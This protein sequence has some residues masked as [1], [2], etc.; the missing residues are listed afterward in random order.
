ML[1]GIVYGEPNRLFNSLSYSIP[2]VQVLA[3]PKDPQTILKIITDEVLPKLNDGNKLLNTNI[4][5]SII[6]A[7]GLKYAVFLLFFDFQMS[8]E[9]VK[10]FRTPNF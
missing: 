1:N 2:L 3:H 4:P 7:A 9:L 6:K 10:V 5:E 8:Y